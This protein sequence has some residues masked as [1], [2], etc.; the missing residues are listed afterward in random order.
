[1]VELIHWRVIGA[2]EQD[3]QPFSE[4]DGIGHC[5]DKQSSGLREVAHG[6]QY[7]SGGLVEVL[8][9]RERGHDVEASLFKWD[10]VILFLVVEHDA[11]A[12][13]GGDKLVHGSGG[14]C[15]AAAE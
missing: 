11:L 13:C 3:G 8:D 9:H 4:I 15:P 10:T 7:A 6:V 1:M 5:Q 14:D 12:V 2:S